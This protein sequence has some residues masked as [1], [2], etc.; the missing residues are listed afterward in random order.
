MGNTTADKIAP[1]DVS[2]GSI[3]LILGIEESLQY[4][5]SVLYTQVIGGWESVALIACAGRL[6]PNSS[7]A[8]HDKAVGLFV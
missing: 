1:K 8:S 4:P 6:I 3:L 5:H 2:C 7:V